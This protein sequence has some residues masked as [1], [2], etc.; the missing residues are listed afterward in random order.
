MVTIR[1]NQ[2]P[3]KSCYSYGSQ[4][5]LG[6][7][8]S[9]SPSTNVDRRRI[10]S[11][12]V[13]DT[14]TTPRWTLPVM[15]IVVVISWISALRFNSSSQSLSAELDLKYHSL[16]LHKEQTRYLIND[17]RKMRD[18]ILRQNRKQQRTK[19]L[20]DH[21]ARMS[22]ELYEMQQASSNADISKL[23][24]QR[25][26]GITTSWVVQRQDALQQ[27]IASLQSIVQN[28]SRKKLVKQHG[29]GPHRVQFDVLTGQDART[30]GSFVVELASIEVVPYSV[31][32]FLDM[33]TSRLW[34]NTVF[35]H[36]SSQ[37][38]V[39]AAAPVNYGT[40]DTKN[41]HF[42]ALGYS[43]LSFPEYSESVPHS[44][45]GAFVNLANVLQIKRF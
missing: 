3:P 42:E 16:G 36:H 22:E 5:P 32:A 39:I 10:L 27:K 13:S 37:S 6:S 8:D 23:I 2:L 26:N 17:A 25:Q 24:E 19:R 45:V 20:F 31:D 1:R 41:H 34:D 44:M 9:L 11:V 7:D 4:L 43:G 38:H 18:S 29:P 28:Q 40:F 21:E 14:L 30:P 35:Y 33:I 12:S 15:C